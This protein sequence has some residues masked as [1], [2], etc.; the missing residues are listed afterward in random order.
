MKMT[1]EGDAVLIVLSLLRESIVRSAEELHQRDP[2]NYENDQEYEL[3]QMS[4]ISQIS[5]LCG[6]YVKGFMTMEYPENKQ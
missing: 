3:A 2:S 4:E 6:V 1:L 5:V